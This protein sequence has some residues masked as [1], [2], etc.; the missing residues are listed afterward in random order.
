MRGP[1][2]SETLGAT[3]CERRLTTESVDSGVAQT[4]EP[5]SSLIERVVAERVGFEPTVTRTPRR[6]SRPVP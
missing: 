6:F 3:P 4:A 2:G 1:T 5:A